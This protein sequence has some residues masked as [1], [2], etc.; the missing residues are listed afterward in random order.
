MALKKQISKADYD[1][2]SDERKKDYKAGEYS[3]TFVLDIDGDETD[4]PAELRRALARE[5][6][7]RKAAQKEARELK[8]KL[9]DEGDEGDDDD[10]EN[11]PPATGRQRRGANRAEADAKKID[12][13]WKKKYDKDTAARDAKLSAKDA[14]IKKTMVDGTAERIAAKI[15]TSPKLLA[16]AIADRLTVDFD[17]DTPELVILGD[18]G[19]PSGISL[20]KLEKEFVANK[21]YASIMIASKASGGGAPKA[22]ADLPKPGGGA[23]ASENQ[24]VTDLSKMSGKDLAATL[25]AR[26]EAVETT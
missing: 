12:A 17:G 10:G 9:G 25:K 13:D 4:D 19:K 20:D 8:A 23:P 16:K 11:D 24:Q 21:E 26:K 7:D 6:A 14:F 18:D 15:S 3:D 1:K 2:L 5:K 22:G